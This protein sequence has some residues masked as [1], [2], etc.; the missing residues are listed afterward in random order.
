M[1]LFNK[2]KLEYISGWLLANMQTI[3]VAE[4]VT[5]GL[6]QFAFSNMEN[7]AKFFQGGITAYNLG[8]KYKHLEVE[9]IHAQEINCV[10]DKVAVQMA[11][12]VCRQFNSQWGIGITGYCSPVPESGNKIYAYYAVIFNEDL[13]RNE[14]IT[15][16]ATSPPDVQL[17]YAK[18][19]MDRLME[20]MKALS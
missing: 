10:S 6:L 9:P 14:K 18:I 8:Q 3:A 12:Q 16:T 17:D 5:A 4:S 19:V 13:L 20:S 2:N 7:A 1:E 15:S 11:R